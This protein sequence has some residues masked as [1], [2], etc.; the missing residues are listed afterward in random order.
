M[1]KADYKLLLCL[2]YQL[3]PTLPSIVL[4]PTSQEHYFGF[5]AQASV[6]WT[7]NGLT[8]YIISTV[9]GFEAVGDLSRWKPWPVSSITLP[10]IPYSDIF[11]T[12]SYHREEQQR[13]QCVRYTNFNN[14]RQS[15][16]RQPGRTMHS[17][18]I[19]RRCK[20]YPARDRLRA[21]SGRCPASPFPCSFSLFDGSMQLYLWVNNCEQLP[22]SSMSTYLSFQ[23]L[24]CRLKPSYLSFAAMWHIRKP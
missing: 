19:W 21:S 3:L 14:R 16:S 17:G 12:R 7:D 11:Y 2:E 22:P 15:R 8:G 6:S 9:E 4:T 23:E 1:S 13:L 24:W 5:C 18:S 10:I 20:L